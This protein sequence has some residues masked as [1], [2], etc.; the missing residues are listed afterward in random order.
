MNAL[1]TLLNEHK[2]EFQSYM[3]LLA[4]LEGQVRP[5][6]TKRAGAVPSTA[7][8]KAMKATAF[9]MLYNVIE[10]TIVGAM[11]HLYKTIENEQRKLTDVSEKIQ[12]LWISQ[13]FR[14]PARDATPATYQKRAA[15]MLRETMRGAILTLDPRDLGVGGNIDADKVRR[16]CIRHGWSMTAHK[17]A[18]GGAELTTVKTQRNA[19]AH[20][21]KTFI[22]CGQGYAVSDIQRISAE[23]FTFLS[24]FVTSVTRFVDRSGYR[25]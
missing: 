18:K 16:L 9:L 1:R 10:A 17:N 21:E 12:D 5:S 6:A 7:T 24:G 4:H 15:Q 13:R 23:C 20:G 8:F 2:K 11:A 19:L 22:E 3:R 14:V 25:R